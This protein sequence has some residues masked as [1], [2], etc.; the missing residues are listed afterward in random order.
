MDI[1]RPRPPMR[2]PRDGDFPEREPAIT[3]PSNIIV[4]NSGDEKLSTRARSP[5]R[6]RMNIPAATRVPK[7]LA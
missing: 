7:M 5:G 3:S 6:K 4:K 1:M 2:R